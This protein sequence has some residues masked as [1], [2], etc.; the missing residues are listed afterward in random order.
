MSKI[1]IDNK[2]Y[3]IDSLS[4]NARA[5]L[6]SIRYVDSEIARLNLQLAA[7]QTA[8]NAYGNA[9]REILDKGEATEEEK[10]SIEELGDNLEFD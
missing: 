2:E 1:N 7:M 10:I 3:E 4:E 8:R 6:A 9:L 5:Q